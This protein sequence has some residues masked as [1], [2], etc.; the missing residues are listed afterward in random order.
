MSSRR[1]SLRRHSLDY[2]N[3]FQGEGK[4][5]PLPP[6]LSSQ[7][8]AAH[9][10]PVRHKGISVVLPSTCTSIKESSTSLVLPGLLLSDSIG[11]SSLQNSKEQTIPGLAVL[12]NSKP[13]LTNE[14]GASGSSEDAKKDGSRAVSTSTPYP[15][16][17]PGTLPIGVKNFHSKS[18]AGNGV[19]P[20]IVHDAVCHAEKRV[21]IQLHGSRDS[22]NAVKDKGKKIKKHYHPK[23]ALTE[24]HTTPSSDPEGNSWPQHLSI[25][26]TSALHNCEAQRKQNKSLLCALSLHENTNAALLSP[27][28]FTFHSPPC[29][30]PWNGC[31]SFY[32]S[33]DAVS[34]KQYLTRRF[35]EGEDAEEREKQQHSEGINDNIENGSSCKLRVSKGNRN[36]S[37]KAQAERSG[38]EKSTSS[39]C[40]SSYEKR[41]DPHAL[42]DLVLHLPSATRPER[43]DTETPVCRSQKEKHE[44][45]LGDG[46]ISLPTPCIADCQSL[47]APPTKDQRSPP[48]AQRTE[49]QHQ[50]LDRPHHHSQH[51][52]SD[53]ATDVMQLGEL[54]SSVKNVRRIKRRNPRLR[55]L[56]LEV[57]CA[58]SDPP[59]PTASDSEVDMSSASSSKDDG[60]NGHL[61]R[62]NR[63]SAPHHPLLTSER[64]APQGQSLHTDKKAEDG[65]PLLTRHLV[66]D[67]LS[68]VSKSQ[69][70][71]EY[72]HS[73]QRKNAHD[74]LAYRHQHHTSHKHHQGWRGTT[75]AK[76]SGGGSSYPA[77]QQ[78][79]PNRDSL[80]R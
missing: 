79:G 39:S 38:F 47:H 74:Y 72:F 76:V 17:S 69:L 1:G 8:D 32:E 35:R 71:E 67:H 11:V 64:T 80:R 37:L 40:I 52:H 20:D 12:C 31:S 53:G 46:V 54:S 6:T 75:V 58:S 43:P 15:C 78:L 10:L 56:N 4:P 51:Y 16:A 13:S 70:V 44:D 42:K 25:P 21:E 68:S 45:I 14:H 3:S 7:Q 62:W 61:P 28:A 60:W 49:P 24:I 48:V 41:V 27:Q 2:P 77:P 57:A 50:P 34:E 59:F 23:E 36:K 33:S 66:K 26:V 29:S 5:P 22:Q 63:G 55:L 73:L 19:P 18:K 30:Y 65:A 9:L